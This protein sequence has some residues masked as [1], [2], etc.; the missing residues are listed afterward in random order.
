MKMQKIKHKG[1][2]LNTNMFRKANSWAASYIE[3][4][5]MQAGSIAI[6]GH[7]RPDGDDV[8]SCLGLYNYIKI[9][10]PD[11]KVIVFLEEFSSDFNFL[12]GANNVRSDYTSD[13]CFDLAFTMDCAEPSRIGGFAKY[14]ESAKKKIC[15]DHHITSDGSGYDLAVISPDRSSTCETLCTVIDM[16]RLDKETAECIYLGIV[17]DTGVFKHDNTGFET[18]IYAGKLASLGVRTEYIIDQTFYK[19]TFAANRALGKALIEAKLLLDGKLIY[20]VF[21]REMMEEYQVKRADL[22][23]V[24]DQLRV[25]E[26]C[27]CALFIYETE[28]GGTFKVSL[29]ANGPIDV[30][31]IAK[32]FGGGGHVKAA[33]C[34][35][36]ASPNEIIDMISLEIAKQI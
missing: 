35:I 32:K 1:A 8:G 36:K 2:R 34:D 16:E 18:H 17:H 3:D 6:L 13:E 22:D 33:G 9:I 28:E 31:I 20:S 4:A 11:A 24:I 15:I 21:T 27:L 25:T 10:H 23:G 7:V 14:M 29:R 19:K 5:I 30:S 12:R 26:G